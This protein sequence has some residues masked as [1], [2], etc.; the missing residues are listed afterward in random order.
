MA[1]NNIELIISAKDQASSVL[2]N[3]SSAL[4]NLLPPLKGIGIAVAGISA[5]GGTLISFA[6]K[7]ADA[8]DELLEMSKRIGVSVSALSELKYAGELT[9]TSIGSLES[10]MR[11][12][13]KRMNDAASGSKEASQIFSQLN[14]SIKDSSGNLRNADAVLMDAVDRI[15]SLGSE[16]KKTAMAMEL[17]GRS[18]AD[19]LPFIKE[20]SKG[21]AELREE[22]NKLGIVFSE[23]SAKAADE[24][25]DN[26]SRMTG[27]ITGIVYSIGNELIPRLNQ[28][29]D[30]LFGKIEKT[31][32]VLGDF[33]KSVM[34]GMGLFVKEGTKLNEIINVLPA[35]ELKVK[36]EKIAKSFEETSK[37]TKDANEHIKAYSKYLKELGDSVAPETMQQISDA[38]ETNNVSWSIA[39]E[40]MKQ[41]E[42]AY[43]KTYETITET[44]QEGAD[45]ITEI[46]GDTSTMISDALNYTNEKQ[47]QTSEFLKESWI[48]IKDS[49]RASF[50]MIYEGFG[51]AVGRMIVYGENFGA[52]FKAILS[53]ILAAF[54]SIIAQMIA[55]WVM[56][57]ILTGGFGAGAG[58]LKIF[59]F[60]K[61]GIT[62]GGLTPLSTSVISAADGGIFKSPTLAL[63]GDNPERQEAVIPM[64]NGKVPVELRGDTNNGGSQIYIKELSIMQ[65]ATIDEALTNKSMDFWIN[66]VKQKILPSINELGSNGA[67]TTLR[68]REAY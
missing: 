41:V 24:F 65:G 29:F 50:Q 30:T 35:N 20:G 18:G 38:M 28:V 5:I 39:G 1:E 19:L 2:G 57:T 43:S 4:Q 31:D 25:K 6:K 62:E 37:H 12:L 51:V 60:A 48:T 44:T 11:L 10:G 53:S 49:A 54:I 21:I 63:I 36:N 61:G 7:T 17:F 47:L 16:T 8:G 22:A 40:T 45:I 14:I 52:N 64:Q 68:L 23:K 27:H 15:N 59:G 26:L 32:R 13:S 56:F 55:R 66:L 34:E 9:G 3:V 42:S 33:E 58:T 67:T 46:W